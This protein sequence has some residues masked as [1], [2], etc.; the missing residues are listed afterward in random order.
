MNFFGTS[1]NSLRV[2]RKKGA[3]GKVIVGEEVKSQAT[4]RLSEHRHQCRD[5]AGNKG[6][7]RGKLDWTE[8]AESRGG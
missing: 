3:S 7:R 1:S 6:R 8:G 4:L 2:C 5:A